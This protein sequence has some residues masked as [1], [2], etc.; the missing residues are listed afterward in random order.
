MLEEILMNT[1]TIFLIIATVPQFVTTYK[2]RHNLKD[3]NPKFFSLTLCGNIF[4]MAWATL[5]RYL[6]VFVLNMAYAVWAVM[7]LYL[8]LSKR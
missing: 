8:I 6:A 7:T 5:M 4:T 2:N 3:L 1:G